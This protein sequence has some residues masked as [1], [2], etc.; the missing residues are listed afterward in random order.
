M[1]GATI[2]YMGIL[3]GF[4]GD[5]EHGI[6]LTE[7]GMQLNPNHPGWH[8]MTA[9]HNAYRVKD[10]PK[11]LELALK[12]NAPKNPRVQRSLTVATPSLAEIRKQAMRCA[13]C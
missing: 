7:R 4:S 10:Y 5:W 13:I 6:S 12:L 11:A 1:D 9:W 3:M 2:A 8:L